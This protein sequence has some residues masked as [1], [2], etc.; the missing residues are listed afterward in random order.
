MVRQYTSAYGVV[1]RAEIVLLTADGLDN[2]QIGTRLD[3]PRRIV[4]KSRK[5]FCEERLAVQRGLSAG[6]LPLP[7]VGTADVPTFA[8]ASAGRRG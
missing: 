5:R 1:M 2:K 8:K 3:L 4:S 7:C 6:I